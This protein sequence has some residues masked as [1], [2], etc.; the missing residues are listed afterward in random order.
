LAAWV[1][2][3][4]LQLVAEGL[5]RVV[6]VVWL[7]QCAVCNSKRVVVVELLYEFPTL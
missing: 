2:A 1:V 5:K 7:L 3:E 6:V 4:P